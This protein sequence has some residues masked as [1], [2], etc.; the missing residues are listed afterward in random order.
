ME[1][2]SRPS[3]PGTLPSKLSENQLFGRPVE[4]QDLSEHSDDPLFAALK[5]A[6]LDG[7]ITKRE[8]VKG[9]ML[10]D[11]LMLARDAAGDDSPDRHGALAQFVDELPVEDHPAMVAIVNGT[12]RTRLPVDV[13]PSGY[14]L[15]SV[16]PKFDD[17]LGYVVDGTFPLT[18]AEVGRADLDALADA[19]FGTR[20]RLS[21]LLGMLV[22]ARIHDTVSFRMLITLLRTNADVTG[23]SMYQIGGR[24]YLPPFMVRIRGR[25]GQ[26]R[27]A[28]QFYHLGNRLTV[29]LRIARVALAL[30]NHAV[31]AGL[32]VLPDL[33]GLYGDLFLAACSLR[34]TSIKSIKDWFQPYLSLYPEGLT[35]GVMKNDFGLRFKV[36][37][38]ETF[39]DSSLQIRDAPQVADGPLAYNRYVM[40]AM[41]LDPAVASRYHQLS[42]RELSG[43]EAILELFGY[44]R[45]LPL[46]A[47][48]EPNAID[49][50]RRKVENQLVH[51]C[52]SATYT[53]FFREAGIRSRVTS[54][55]E[56]LEYGYSPARIFKNAPS[57]TSAGYGRVTFK[58]V[59]DGDR[60][61]LSDDR[62]PR[63][64][65]K[66]SRLA[67]EFPESTPVKLLRS[68]GYSVAELVRAEFATTKKGG[69]LVYSLSDLHAVLS[70]P[71]AL[72]E[73]ISFLVAGTVGT[74]FV[75]FKDP[76]LIFLIPV[77]IHLALQPLAGVMTYMAEEYDHVFIRSEDP[78]FGTTH[79]GGILRSLA[80]SQALSFGLDWGTWDASNYASK[81]SG[82]T[83]ALQKEFATDPSATTVFAYSH[84]GEPFT[85]IEFVC[86]LIYITYSGIFVRAG[87]HVQVYRLPSGSPLTSLVGSFDNLGQVSALL[88]LMSRVISDEP[89]R[90]RTAALGN[91][92]PFVVSGRKLHAALT[93]AGIPYP[94]DILVLK[95]QVAM[96]IVQT[97]GDDVIAAFTRTHPGIFIGLVVLMVQ[98]A[99]KVGGVVKL[100]KVLMNPSLTVFVRKLI[101]GGQY[102]PRPS[103]NP[104][105]TERTDAAPFLDQM[106]RTI[107]VLGECVARGAHPV[108][109]MYFALAMIAIGGYESQRIIGK[110]GRKWAEKLARHTRVKEFTIEKERGIE[111][112][113]R[114][115]IPL[116][117]LV[118]PDSLNL[119]LGLP[120]IPPSGVATS[121]Y[122]HA[123]RIAGGLSH[124]DALYV[125]LRTEM[126][127]R[128]D[129]TVS[130]ALDG[131]GPRIDRH[132]HSWVNAVRTVFPDF[133]T[134]DV[135]H[136]LVREIDKPKHAL[137][138]YISNVI[139]PRYMANAFVFSGAPHW[140]NASPLTKSLP[141]DTTPPSEYRVTM[142]DF[143]YQYLPD[144]GRHVLRVIRDL[145]TTSPQSFSL[146]LERELRNTPVTD[147][148]DVFE[149]VVARSISRVDNPLDLF[150]VITGVPVKRT[151]D[152]AMIDFIENLR[153][154]GTRKATYFD[155]YITLASIVPTVSSDTALLFYRSMFSAIQK[156]NLMHISLMA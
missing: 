52:V 61:I 120:F 152:R 150:A 105:S 72:A 47:F 51:D 121:G 65:A 66:L 118:H 17:E 151:S 142:M 12:Y 39:L 91:A 139:A 69:F 156:V 6:D 28:T 70:S 97:M 53:H 108:A 3:P 56:L 44:R 81:M 131:F 125:L 34:V 143:V 77:F 94:T 85:V 73:L 14:I 92:P 11:R 8:F 140:R 135:N 88:V 133:S 146:R 82:I 64:P 117:N 46:P 79:L 21:E 104:I 40:A 147:A 31:L 42:R 155:S 29:N 127:L 74:R 22:C 130:P 98:F 126:W 137:T 123:L 149:R 107:Q 93:A 16:P 106:T 15:P 75:P 122:E 132:F 35:V 7:R 148:V 89:L 9:R 71:T 115:W 141:A 25:A 119:C 83:L 116:A 45:G 114:Y 55:R 27:W 60:L 54:L 124:L 36:D 109:T 67:K 101:V 38:A 23:T 113:V 2:A 128:R 59:Q 13:P 103:V 20:T 110:T 84:D 1:T 99:E 87:L 4:K 111:T 58:L 153:L 138:R 50:D 129:S 90:S 95:V 63:P 78:K 49:I 26:K 62:D 19:G 154:L 41:N 48:R 18:E 5:A 68:L 96:R 134:L 57:D 43:C 145:G 76:R 136:E 24:D 10:L 86:L 33:T 102:V 37:D 80:G 32:G 112:R 100:S 30:A 144:I